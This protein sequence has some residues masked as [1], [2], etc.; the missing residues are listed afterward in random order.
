MIEFLFVDFIRFIESHESIADF[1]DED[2]YSD[3]YYE[4]KEIEIQG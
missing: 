2:S 4:N 1:S 3:G